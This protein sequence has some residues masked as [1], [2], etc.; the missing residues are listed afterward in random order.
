MSKQRHRIKGRFG[1]LPKA[2]HDSLAYRRLSARAAKLLLDV[3]MQFDGSNNGDLHAAFGPLRS[4]GWP[5]KATLHRATQ[6]LIEAGLILKTRTGGRNQCALYAL[7]WH[8][9]DEVRDK[10]TGKL[11][12]DV[13]GVRPGASVAVWKSS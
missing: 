3:L 2:V 13:P 4:F 9:I 5:S 7:T 12:F 8:P 6:E 11:K 10:E 1:M